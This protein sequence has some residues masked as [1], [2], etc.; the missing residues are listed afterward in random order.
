MLHTFNQLR[1]YTAEGEER[2]KQT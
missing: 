1:A 2:R